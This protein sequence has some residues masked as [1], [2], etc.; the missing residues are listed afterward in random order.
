MPEEPQ[1]ETTTESDDRGELLVGLDQARQRFR[2]EAERYGE[3]L[4]AAGLQ[5]HITVGMREL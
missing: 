2:A 4:A 1:E 3:L 5:L